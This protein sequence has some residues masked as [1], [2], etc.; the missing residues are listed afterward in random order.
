MSTSGSLRPAARFGIAVALLLA[1]AAQGAAADEASD[2]PLTRAIA[3]YAEA[4]AQSDRDARLAGP[5]P[6]GAKIDVGARNLA[7]QDAAA[8]PVPAFDHQHL[9]PRARQR[10][11]DGEAGEAGADDQDVSAVG[12]IGQKGCPQMVRDS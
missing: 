6:G 4:L 12:D 7:R 8:N 1:L 9:P 11:G 3:A 2:G 10:V 5:E